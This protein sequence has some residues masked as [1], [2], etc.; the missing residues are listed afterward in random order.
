MKRLVL[1]INFLLA[2]SG[3][4][5][6]Q[7][8]NPFNIRPAW[9]SENH[10]GAVYAVAYHPNGRI[11]ATGGIDGVVRVWNVVSGDTAL[12]TLRGHTDSVISLAFR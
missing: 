2:I 8:I 5:F 11:L 10:T 7:N 3:L 9:S 1:I 6:G 4:A 12:L